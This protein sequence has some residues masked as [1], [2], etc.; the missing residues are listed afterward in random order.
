[1]LIAEDNSVNALILKYL[2]NMNCTVDHVENGRLAVEYALRDDVDVIFMDVHMPV[3]DG[4]Q[5]TEKYGEV[6]LPTS[7]RSLEQPPMRLAKSARYVFK[8]A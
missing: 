6:E 5:A 3:L 4:L 8:R 2:G 1:M 7:F